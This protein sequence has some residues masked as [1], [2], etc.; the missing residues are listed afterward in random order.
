M[1]TRR[2]ARQILLVALL[3]VATMLGVFF[4]GFITG[5]PAN[6]ET[7]K[8]EQIAKEIIAAC[9]LADPGDKDARDACGQKLGNSKLLASSTAVPVLWGTQPKTGDF[10]LKA[11][12][13]TTK[14]HPLVMWR[15][16]LSVFMFTG[17]YKIEQVGDQ[18]S[19]YQTIIHM[20]YQ[21]R[22]K[23]D[24][25]E[26]P[27]PYWH[28]K[29][30]WDAFQYSPEVDVVIEQGKVTGVIRA[31][32]RDR[33][34][35]YVEHEWDGRWHWTGAAG[36]QEPRVTLF[37]YLLSKSNPYVEQLD[38]AY[39]TLDTESRKHSCQV[40]HNPGNPS[41]MAPLGIMEYPNQ[42]LTI[43]HRIV[44]V[45]EANRMPPAGI[46]SKDGQ[47]EMIPA[48]ITDEAERQKY[49]KAARDFAELGDKAL[50]FEGQPIN[51]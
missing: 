26:Y 37:K 13:N 42:A 32:E 4:A 27:Y 51:Y 14:F 46:A 45:M 47:Q 43:R 40:C 31:A 38:A 5:Q 15:V 1:F 25:G 22:N 10:N 49:L 48:G 28:S 24:I 50:A 30:K 21:Y 16:Y 41:L 29:K 19:G 8:A 6:A 18:D 34:R 33:S 35:P 36:E 3:A 23:L 17:D 39:R 12:R 2:K 7:R 9:P 11:N 20:P 44:K